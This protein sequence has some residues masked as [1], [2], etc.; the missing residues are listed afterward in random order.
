MD[1]SNLEYKIL[2]KLVL[3]S[4]KEQRRARRWRIFFRL[5]WLVIIAGILYAVFGGTHAGSK[6][7]KSVAVVSLR[8]VIDDDNKSYLNLRD[9]LQDALKDDNTVGVIIRAN[10][11]G[12]SPVYSNMA[13]D[14]ILRLRKLYPKKPI[15]VVVE[16]MC[17]SGCY[18]IASA[19]DKIYASP[20]SIVGSI[21]VIY[22]GFGLTGLIDK[23]GVDSRLM[24]SGKN[25]AA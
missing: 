10:S 3:E 17:A 25:K 9:G 5:C 21:G 4:V 12:G 20:A 15:E 6:G 8:G 13:Y 1:T 18:Y 11:P 7:G 14:E 23:L 16:E 19:A 24:I 22:A 2:E